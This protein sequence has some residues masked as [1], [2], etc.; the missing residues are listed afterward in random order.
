MIKIYRQEETERK[1]SL[2]IIMVNTIQIKYVNGGDY[3]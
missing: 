2:E 1:S 3:V